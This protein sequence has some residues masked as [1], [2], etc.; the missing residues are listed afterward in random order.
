MSEKDVKLDLR[1]L[2]F[3]TNS[4]ADVLIRIVDTKNVVSVFRCNPITVTLPPAMLFTFPETIT[5]QYFVHLTCC[6]AK[7]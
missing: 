5:I 1:V 6:L 2:E 4:V 7:M 3:G